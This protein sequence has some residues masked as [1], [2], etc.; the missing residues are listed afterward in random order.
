MNKTFKVIY[1]RARLSVTAVSEIARSVHKKGTKTVLA[2]G[3]GGLMMS[4]VA[5]AMNP[6]LEVKVN[7]EVVEDVSSVQDWTFDKFS[8]VVQDKTDVRLELTNNSDSNSVNALEAKTVDR[9]ISGMESFKIHQNSESDKAKSA[10]STL[11]ASNEKTLM[12]N[13]VKNLEIDTTSNTVIHAFGGNVTIDGADNVSILTTGNAVMAQTNGKATIEAT[14]S[15]LLKST[16]SPTVFAGNFSNTSGK[17]SV[18]IKS[19][20]SLAVISDS[21]S[22]V[23]VNSNGTWNGNKY[24]GQ[25]AGSVILQ[26]KKG[27]SLIGETDGLRI[28]RLN[29]SSEKTVVKISSDEFVRIEATEKKENEGAISVATLSESSAETVIDAPQI[30]LNGDV[31]LGHYFRENNTLNVTFDKTGAEAADKRKL[32]LNGTTTINGEVKAASGTLVINGEAIFNKNATIGKLEGVDGKDTQLTLGDKDATISVAKNEVGADKLTL[33]ATGS[34]NDALGGDVTKL[35]D[36][37][38]GSAL[39]DGATVKMAEGMAAGEVTAKVGANGTLTDVTTKTNSVMSNVLD[40]SSVTALSL[41]RILM[42]DVRKRLGDVRSTEGA[43]GAWVRYDGGKLTGSNSLKNNFTTVQMGFDTVPSQDAPRFGAALAYTRSDADMRR[44][45]ATMDTYS[46]ALYGTKFFENGLFVDV[47]GRAALSNADYTVD[48][49]KKGSADNTALSLSGEIGWRY[50][51]TSTLFVEPQAEL[52]YTYTDAD[53]LKLKNA[54]SEQA[55]SFDKVDSLLGRVG[56][57]AGYTCPE[58]RGNVYVHASAVHE[59]LGDATIRSGLNSYKVNGEDT[60]AEYGIGAN[61]NFS[62]NA[63]IYAGL[64]RT[65][66]GKLDEEWRAHLGVRYAF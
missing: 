32:T 47:I 51:A 11:Y 57:A 21:S 61:Y 18:E 38:Q 43:H 46:L 10:D 3:I 35:K 8:D 39:K 1:S 37:F 7:D 55:Y 12:I 9:T 19:E 23:S 56:F 58:G 52:T 5:A 31:L 54:T 64:E 28:R 65:D 13:G 53:T 50:D 60:W 33:G 42:N 41:N 29:Q 6:Y 20:G 22:A 25:G 59:F 63:Y 30:I 48:S 17:A 15:I 14:E 45:D 24:N 4:G 16:G 62:K 2:V 66:G 34:V 40:I 26:G 27:V 36:K 49:D 44:G